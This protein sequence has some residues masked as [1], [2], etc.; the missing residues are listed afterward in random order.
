M[1]GAPR[2]APG[3]LNARELASATPATRNRFVD[4]IR[5]ASIFVVVLGHWLMAVLG[6]H[7]GKFTGKNLLEI[8]PGLQ[9]LTWIFQVMPLFFIVGGF[10]N[11]ISWSSA[12]SR[13]TSYADWLRT[14]SAR[15]LRPALWFVGFWAILPV[16]A[17]AAGVLPSG[18]ARIGGQEVALP[19]WFLAVYVVAV[20]AIPPLLVVHRRFGAWALA[21]LAIGALLVDS[22]RFGLDVPFIGV[23][24]YALVWLAVIELGF[25]WGEG[26]L[27][28]YRWLPWV[29]AGGGLIALGILVGWFDYP[30]S[31]IGLT[32]GI[33]SNT[34]PPSGALLALA[35]WQCGAMLLL[36]DAANR[37]LARARP[38]LGVVIANS[39]VMTFYLWNMSAVV[40]AAVILFPTGIA[41]Q[42]EPLSASWWWLR[43]AWIVTCAIC[44]APLLFGFRWAE[45]P[46]RVAAA[47]AR[48]GLAG[49]V[50]AVTGVAAA[51][52]GL[53]TLAWEAFPVPDEAVALPSAGAALVVA[54]AALLRVNPI[55]SLRASPA[56]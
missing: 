8:D 25:F 14:R 17:V 54:G 6:Y 2:E 5:V 44:L 19:L 9:I 16:V 36:E 20:A 45:R 1:E 12:Q 48:P 23:A 49:I 46:T 24:N 38:W 40:L 7:D 26:A 42:P 30:V 34:L 41:P 22:F 15:L 47:L 56:H 13:G 51:A 18:V 11:A 21:A 31:M 53:M 39:M 35:V 50:Q 4:L 55:A 52:T 10:T 43:P 3:R 33:R 28:R 32:H 37:W 29:M 27:R